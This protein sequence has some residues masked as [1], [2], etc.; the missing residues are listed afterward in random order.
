M[1]L[2]I[3]FGTIQ[4]FGFYIT[5]EKLCISWTEDRLPKLQVSTEK[6]NFPKTIISNLGK[7]TIMKR[8]GPTPRSLWTSM[9]HAIEELF[10]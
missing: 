10:I 9:E 5:K 4:D 8:E 3:L 6:Q 7:P 1:F 2:H